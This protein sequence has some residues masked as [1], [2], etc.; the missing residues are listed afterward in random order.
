MLEGKEKF[1]IVLFN[2]PPRSGK[3]TACDYAV[4]NFD[5][6]TALVKF[7]RPIK[8][9]CRKFY[10]L[11]KEEWD[12]YDSAANK[13]KESSTFYGKTCREAQ[14]AIS[15]IFAKPFHGDQAIFGK[16]FCRNVHK[17]YNGGIIVVS[18][19]GFVE[20]AVEACSFFGKDNI[21]LVR[22]R[23]PGCDY[24]K[25]SRNYIYLEDLGVKCFELENDMPLEVYHE[26]V[27]GIMRDVIKRYKS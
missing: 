14:I 18:D 8:D 16:I 2:G 13:D 1:H 6:V 27:D 5:E 20:E 15:E 17:W 26:R 24:T 3:D 23:R 7:A 9:A 10:G 22:V 4:S 11:T 21:T 25:D 19:S 12:Y